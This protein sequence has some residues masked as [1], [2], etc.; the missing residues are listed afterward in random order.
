MSKIIVGIDF[1]TSTTVV[2]W[3]MENDP[4]IHSVMD[5]NYDLINSV[6]YPEDG[7][8]WEFGAK[9]CKRNG[10]KLITNFKMNL[11]SPQEEQAEGYVRK[12][13]EFVYKTFCKNIEDANVK[14]DSMD[15]Y[16]SYPV[17]WPERTKT[18]MKK[19][20]ADSGFGENEKNIIQGQVEPVA[21]ASELIRTH[22]GDL[23]KEGI[24]KP[25]APSNVLMLDMGAGT[26]DLLLFQ[27]TINDGN[28]E[29]PEDKIVIHPVSVGAKNCGGREI[30]D[31]L[32]T[33]VHNYLHKGDRRPQ[34]TDYGI[35]R[36]KEWKDQVVS[37]ELKNNYDNVE[38]PE[39][40]R[41]HITL[42]NSMGMWDDKVGRYEMNRKRFE[43]VTKEHWN[44]L[45]CLIKEGITKFKEEC[46]IGAEDIDIIFL[47]GGHSKWY[48]VPQIFIGE[49][50]FISESLKNESL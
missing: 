3:R 10:V 48:C 20:V 49:G 2:R 9:A 44:N 13:M 36:I 7:E 29:I 41:G 39:F 38:I 26:S 40:I 4:I 31:A 42:L 34:K 30:D 43:E 47:T 37:E 8:S 5:G 45:Y 19:I 33:D 27:L 17:K 16:V 50:N 11:I 24:L 46:N 28:I 1:G 14:Y 6:I 35:N 15:V 25:N 21:V 22:F 32:H 18:L 23:I 12:F